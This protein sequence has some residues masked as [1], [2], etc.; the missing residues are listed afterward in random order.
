MPGYP[1]DATFAGYGLGRVHTPSATTTFAVPKLRCRSADQ[2]SARSIG[3]VEPGGFDV[4][5]DSPATL[6]AGYHGGK[7]HC[8]PELEVA[9]TIKGTQGRLL[10][11]VTRSCSAPLITGV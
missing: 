4:P 5:P 11:L 2:A 6:F 10:T 3:A 9:S 1:G 8:W 7:P